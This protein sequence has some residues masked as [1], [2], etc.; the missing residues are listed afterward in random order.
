MNER[1]VAITSLQSALAALELAGMQRRGELRRRLR[2]G[3]EE[4]TALLH[5]AHHERLAQRRLG[6]LTGLS[7]SG[8]GAMI[9]RLEEHGYVRRWADPEDRRLRWIELTPAGREALDGASPVTLDDL[10]TEDLVAAGRVLDQLVGEPV[11]APEADDIA[12]ADGVPVWRH[13]G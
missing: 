13:W 5:L 12:P 10:T 7:R 4:L 6:E 9:Q 1:A 2:V 3:D 11:S 8:A